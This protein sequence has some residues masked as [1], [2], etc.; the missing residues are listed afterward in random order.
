MATAH[1]I[2]M[3]SA[4]ALAQLLTAPLRPENT[5]M[6]NMCA[7]ARIAQTVASRAESSGRNSAGQH[8]DHAQ[9]LRL[10]HGQCASIRLIETS[11]R[12]CGPGRDGSESGR[13]VERSRWARLS[14]R[15]PPCWA[16]FRTTCRACRGLAVAWL[17]RGV[18]ATRS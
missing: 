1:G 2:S 18:N 11:G 3:Q 16:G 4:S 5:V 6:V 13:S 15:L 8:S 7:I 17:Q 12:R 10:V 9:R 14:N